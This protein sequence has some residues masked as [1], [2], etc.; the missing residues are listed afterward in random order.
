MA[1]LFL[2]PFPKAGPELVV[3]MLAAVLLPSAAVLVLFGCGKVGR[4][5]CCYGF[6]CWVDV[7]LH[8]VLVVVVGVFVFVGGRCPCLLCWCDAGFLSN[9]AKVGYV[10]SRS[11]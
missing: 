3:V 2:P 11:K 7:S 9:L 4:G 10:K 6:L 5:G 1:S 8:L